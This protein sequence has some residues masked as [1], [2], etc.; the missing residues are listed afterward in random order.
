M[1]ITSSAGSS[2]DARDGRY[3]IGDVATLV[4]LSLRTARFYED[5]GL[6]APV[7]HTSGG[8]PL[9]DDDALDRFFLIKKMKP[10]GFTLEE[11]RSL[12]TLRERISQPDLAP[13][14]RRELRERLRT[15]V[16]LA[17][18]KL[19]SLQEQVRLAEDFMIGLRD[20]TAR[21][22]RESPDHRDV[23][24][25]DDLGPGRLDSSF[26]D[27]LDDPFGPEEN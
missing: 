5:A 7:G 3:R 4:T 16:T 25:K 14:H 24:D 15:W 19:A 9:Y 21:S 13:D 6:L 2:A 23:A 22:L 27:F 10:L 1:S 20:D 18:E 11:M 26:L 12:I 8:F 17:E